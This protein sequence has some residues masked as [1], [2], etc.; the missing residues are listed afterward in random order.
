M[1]RYS[2]T[3][4]QIAP[5]LS[6]SL[7][8]LVAAILFATLG[9]AQPPGVRKV[10]PVPPGVKPPLVDIAV[11]QKE[12]QELRTQRS[13]L[14]K[15]IDTSVIHI[16]SLKKDLKNA[17]NPVTKYF[18]RRQLESQFAIFRD[19]VEQ[20][21][22][23]ETRLSKIIRE[24]GT[25]ISRESGQVPPN[26]IP[27]PSPLPRPLLRPVLLPSSNP[28]ELVPDSELLPPGFEQLPAA[29]K[30]RV[31]KQ[32]ITRIADE[33]KQLQAELKQRQKDIDKLKQI[34]DEL[35]P[36]EDKVHSHTHENE[37]AP[38]KTGT[39]SN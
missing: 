25:R 6:I 13:L 39:K 23:V 7:N 32:E 34:L 3:A 9:L 30:I 18:Y 5:R 15:D 14:E 26:L 8:I 10:I 36:P 37:V 20:L 1:N 22:G 31:I 16:R 29:E 11:L 28:P 27:A 33:R 35:T 21:D 12:A 4:S 24:L 17:D 19:K 38:E 2:Y